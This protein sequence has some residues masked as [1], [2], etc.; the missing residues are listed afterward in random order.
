MIKIIY[1]NEETKKQI[2]S[3]NMEKYTDFREILR[4]MEPAMRSSRQPMVM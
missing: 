4:L 1:L 3:L 2:F